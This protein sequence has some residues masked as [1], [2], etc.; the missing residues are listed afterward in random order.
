MIKNIKCYFNDKKINKSFSNSNFNINNEIFIK[1]VL[2]SKNKDFITKLINND[3]FILYFDILKLVIKNDYFDFFK[4]IIQEEKYN[5]LFYSDNFLLNLA[6][7]FN[8]LK[9][10]NVLLNKEEVIFNK[11]FNSDILFFSCILNSKDTILKVLLHPKLDIKLDN[12]LIETSIENKNI[13]LA[14]ILLKTKK[15]KPNEKCLLKSIYGNHQ[16]LIEILLFDYKIN[17]NYSCLKTALINRNMKIISIL[18]K[19]KYIDYA[20]ENN[21]FIKLA[22]EECDIEL[23]KF[24]LSKKSVNDAIKT[25]DI[26]YDAFLTGDLN[27]IT[28]LF[29]NKT[30]NSNTKK[31]SYTLYQD[32]SKLIISNKV[33]KF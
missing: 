14:I 28:V 17:P 24:L 13:E 32:I 30:I 11:K 20:M 8:N 5:K 6:C 22:C 10:V 7:S 18:L 4:L 21:A 15:I 3:K 1:S 9:M 25:N 19:C 31:Y 27:L 26:I 12:N 29:N 16:D 2:D 23:I 33:N